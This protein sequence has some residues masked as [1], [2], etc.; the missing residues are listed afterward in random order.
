MREHH[1]IIA[2]RIGVQ[3]GCINLRYADI[4]MAALFEYPLTLPRE[5]TSVFKMPVVDAPRC[6][7]DDIWR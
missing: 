5:A 7:L 1:P 6:N 3:S 4:L 2:S